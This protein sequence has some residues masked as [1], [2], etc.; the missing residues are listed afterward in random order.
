MREDLDFAFATLR[1]AMRAYVAAAYG[2]WNDALQHALFA[3]S[4]DLRTHRVLRAD[5]ADVGILAVEVLV[6]RVHLA[7]IF[8]RPDAQGGGLGGRVVRALLAWSHARGLPLVLTVLRT[9][10]AALRFY[11]RLGFRCVGE[12]STHMHLESEPGAAPARNS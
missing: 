5:G 6:D 8:L 11:E 12:T 2:E 4:F 9:N 7:R 10:P 1:E 3:P